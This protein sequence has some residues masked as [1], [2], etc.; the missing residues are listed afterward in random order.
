MNHRPKVFPWI[1][2]EMWSGA[3]Y[4][5]HT[6]THTQ[7]YVHAGNYCCSLWWT[8]CL[9]SELTPRQKGSERA[10]HGHSA[11][12]S[13]TEGGD[14]KTGLSLEHQVFSPLPN[15]KHSVILWRFY[16]LSQNTTRRDAIRSGKYHVV[17]IRLDTLELNPSDKRME[18]NIDLHSLNGG[19]MV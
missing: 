1:I 4:F 3:V 9:K 11:S 19:I 2:T 7:T 17:N 8:R 6:H 12:S 14:G 16:G 18:L 10:P 13:M 5:T 15:T